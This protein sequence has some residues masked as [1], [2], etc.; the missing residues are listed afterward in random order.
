MLRLNPALDRRALAAAYAR[1]GYVQ[2]ETLFADPVAEAIEAALHRTRWR[3]VFLNSAGEIRTLNDDGLRQLT[4]E[5]LG[6]LNDD[7]MRRASSGFGFVYHFY[8]MA[9]TLLAGEDRGHPLHD[10][11]RFLNGR[12]W[13]DFGRT[14]IGCN[15]ITRSDAQ[16]TLYAPGDFLT[17]HDDDY[18]NDVDRR[19][20]FVFSFARD[21]RADWGGQ[22]Q[23]LDAS[24]CVEAAFV[25]RFNVVTFFRV[26]RWHCVSYVP[27]Y[28]GLGRYSVTGWLDHGRIDLPTV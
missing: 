11:V 24:D 12:E 27:P 14:V 21:W 15:T 19:A 28:A 22:L 16:A 5:Q 17:R 25:P 10:L 9:E 4:P 1:D 2:V 18:G 7:L 26:P 6:A 8:P 20:A 3:L 13:L 23:L